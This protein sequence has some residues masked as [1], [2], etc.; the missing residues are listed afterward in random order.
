MIGFVDLGQGNNDGQCQEEAKEALV[1]LVVGVRSPWKIPLAYFLI[2]GMSGQ[3][4][5]QLLLHAL[6]LLHNI[7]IRVTSVTMDGHATNV[8]MCKLLGCSFVPQNIKSWFTD[9]ASGRDIVVFFDACH[10]LKL[11][12][13]ML[14]D[15]KLLKSD[16]GKISWEYIKSLQ[17]LQVGFPVKLTFF[18]VLQ[19]LVNC[20]IIVRCVRNMCF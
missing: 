4:Q 18:K 2:K 3:G 10:M 5:K 16:Q 7:N 9:P 12:R 6:E 20:G 13:N 17:S 19:T 11:A 1:F 15:Y 14:E 8:S